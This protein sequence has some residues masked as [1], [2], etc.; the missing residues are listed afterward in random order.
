MGWM[1]GLCVWF[2]V[3]G[4]RY[5]FWGLGFGIVFGFG[6]EVLERVREWESD[7]WM[8]GFEVDVGLL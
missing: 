5:D 1:E 3:C 4:G 7:G 6:D 8:V 2:Y